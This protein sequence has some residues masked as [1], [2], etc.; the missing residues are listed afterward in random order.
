[1]AIP[2]AREK[3]DRRKKSGKRG[4]ASDQGITLNLDFVNPDFPYDA[5]GKT[6]P[7]IS[8]R[9]YLSSDRTMGRIVSLNRFLLRRP[10]E[11]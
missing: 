11:R 3:G 6:S 2:E 8:S 1:M 7:E 4:Q 9:T 10:I 5:I